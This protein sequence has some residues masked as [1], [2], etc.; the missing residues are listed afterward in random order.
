MEKRKFVESQGIFAYSSVKIRFY[1]CCNKKE[2]KCF[3]HQTDLPS[4]SNNSST[5][6]KAC[7]VL[8]K[9]SFFSHLVTSL[10]QFAII[11]QSNIFKS[12][13]QAMR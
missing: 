12:S 4:P 5:N 7:Q 8:L 3:Y 2:Q 10:L 13:N 9:K 11:L 6:S 1:C